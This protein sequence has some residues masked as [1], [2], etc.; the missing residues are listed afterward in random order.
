MLIGGEPIERRWNRSSGGE[1]G[2]EGASDKLGGG[3]SGVDGSEQMDVNE[4]VDEA[5][6][7]LKEAASGKHGSGLKS[8]N[9]VRLGNR[10]QGQRSP[11]AKRVDW[12]LEEQRWGE[13]S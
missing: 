8:S 10:G 7:E 12:R 1:G 5:G 6:A 13:G 9:G 3:V 11:K 2:D 4:M